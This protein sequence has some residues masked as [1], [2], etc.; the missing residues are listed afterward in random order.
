MARG[1]KII[2]AIPALLLALGC[3]ADFIETNPPELARASAEYVGSSMPE[4]LVW[5]LVA[6][7]YLENP[8]DCPAAISFLRSS[9]N[10]AM[11]AAP[12]SAD[13]GGVSLSDC[14]QPVTRT[15]DPAL[16]DDAVR[17]AETTFAGHAVRAVLLYVNNLAIAPPPQITE[18][19]L[20][21]RARI[22]AR[23]GLQPALWVSLVPSANPGP[24]PADHSVPWSYVGD[25]AY[26][27]TLAQSLSAAVP[28]VSDAALVAGPLPL[29]GG[30][31]LAR[32]REFK[33]CAADEGI[34]AVGFAADGRAV[35]I[36]PVTP[37]QYRVA[38]A[39]RRAIER[40]AFQPL[41]VHVDSEVCLAH[42][43]RLF[44]YAPGEQGV[45]WNA[46]RGCLLQG[47]SR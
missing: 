29:L 44:H 16:I 39:G 36:D 14:T 22:G 2:V 31:D 26:A 45:R 20:T 4:P 30:G 24:L 40:S 17:Q 13:L 27:R 19:I 3:G 33:I 28:F 18:A 37:P 21:A 47:S 41:R 38:L 35:E 23:S 11:P 46:K 15:L 8:A 25:P 43:D 7:L 32:T 5:F 42:C 6:D 34:S 1:R 9:V 10:A 12:L